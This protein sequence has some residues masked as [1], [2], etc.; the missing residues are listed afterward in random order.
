MTVAIKLII[1]IY[2]YI[3]TRTT[4]QI[5]VLGNIAQVYINK[6]FMFIAAADSVGYSQS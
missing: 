1:V 4:K 2:I 5:N 6:Y 3:V